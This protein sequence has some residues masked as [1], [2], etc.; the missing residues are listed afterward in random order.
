M[1]VCLIYP[2]G[3]PTTVWFIFAPEVY[4]L[5]THFKI[6]LAVAK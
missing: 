3:N 5:R 4:L 6:D 2:V 1:H